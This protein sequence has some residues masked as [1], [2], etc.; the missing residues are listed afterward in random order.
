MAATITQNSGAFR[1][2]ISLGG[3]FI[4]RFFSG[5]IP[6]QHTASAAFQ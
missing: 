5:T 1:S 4:A 2:L 3:N 6:A